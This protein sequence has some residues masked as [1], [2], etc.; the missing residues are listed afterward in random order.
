MSRTP[1]IVVG[2]VPPPYH[3]VSV[4]TSLVL[5]NRALAERFDIVHL[6]TSDRRSLENIGRWEIGNVLLGLQAAG[7]LLRLLKGQRGVVYLP[8]SAGGGGFMRDSL[9][10]HLA[11]LRGWKVAT[12]LRAG[13]EFRDV[14]HAQPR[15]VRWWIRLTLGRVDSVGVVGESLRPV[16]EGLVPDDRIAAVSNGT[17]DVGGADPAGRNGT[18]LF[19]SNL[20]ARKG[21]VEAV[22]AARRVL[23]RHPDAKF[24]FAGAWDD[25]D[26]E[27]RVRELAAPAG[28]HIR[29]VPAVNGDGKRDLLHSSSIMLFPPIES[30]GH[31]RVV[32]E[33]MAAGMPLV[34]TDQGAIRDT[35]TDGECGFVLSEADPD[36]LA[37]CVLQ[38]IED[39]ELRG[40]MGRAARTRYLAE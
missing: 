14:Y 18:V 32:L 29:F 39:D 1:L 38:L 16:F 6:D 23:D 2:P 31:P 30:E 8:L 12:H 28:D 34:T 10:I 24:L 22:Q 35:V 19:F 15:P 13:P 20:R 36:R 26:L 4:S 37:E 3:G 5:A 17:P 27:R 9:L 11:R 40:R 33:A 21:L 7:R 25:K